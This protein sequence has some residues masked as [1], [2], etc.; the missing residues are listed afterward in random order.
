MTIK[1]NS[2]KVKKE[3]DKY[4]YLEKKK[5]IFLDDIES[6]IKF[7][8]IK[9]NV[10]FI[11]DQKDEKEE[12]QDGGDMKEIVVGSKGLKGGGWQNKQSGGGWLL[13]GITGEKNDKSQ[14][15]G[16]GWGTYKSKNNS[17]F[18]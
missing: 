4:Y 9:K 13:D 7:H 17:F 3:D 15:G 14:S 8:K 18:D 6:M 2:K 12:S 1:V 5:K 10:N 11:I 16:T